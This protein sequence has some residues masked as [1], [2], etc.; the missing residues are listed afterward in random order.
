MGETT[1]ST[2]LYFN[3]VSFSFVCVRGSFDGFQRGFE[4][5]CTD[6]GRSWGCVDILYLHS[7]R[8]SISFAWKTLNS[9]CCGVNLL[10]GLAKL[11]TPRSPKEVVIIARAGQRCKLVN[12]SV[13]VA[14][15]S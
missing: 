1:A 11:D 7:V 4:S 2:H 13:M 12:F 10:V 6:S 5:Y 15:S 14:I 3:W 8:K 9:S